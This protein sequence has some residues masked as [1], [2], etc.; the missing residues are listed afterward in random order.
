M[1][2]RYEI[3]FP[4][5][6]AVLTQRPALMIHGGGHVMLSR[7]EVRSK[8][9]QLLLENGRLPVSIDYRL[10]PEVNIND[11]PMTDVCDA[12]EWVRNALP[13][14]DLKYPGLN[15]TGEK[16]IVVGWSTGGT[17]AMSLAWS[18]VQRGIKPPDAI[19][20]FYCPTDYHA[21]CM[22]TPFI[23]VLKA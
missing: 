13:Q 3:F 5:H 12:L 21:E 15:I 19:L 16:V 18:S 9:T 14:L 11:G 4:Y 22:R 6:T 7:K 17:L 1:A 8:Q 20:A 23:S 10:C 2:S